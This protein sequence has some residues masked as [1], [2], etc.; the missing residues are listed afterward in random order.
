M[1]ERQLIVHEFDVRG[2]SLPDKIVDEILQSRIKERY[3]DRQTFIKTLRAE[4]STVEKMRRQIREQIIINAMLDKNVSSLLVVSPYKVES[5]YQAH[6]D[7][8]RVEDRVRLRLIMLD[9]SAAAT[10]DERKAL[11]QEI[12]RKIKHGASF[13]EMAALY[14]TGSHRTRGGEWGW[15]TRTELFKGLADIAFELEPGTPGPVIGY[16][17]QPTDYWVCTYDDAGQP[18]VARHFA[19]DPDTR[20]ERLVEERRFEGSS[21]HTNSFPGEVFYLVLVEEKSPAH[22][23]PLSEV[24]DEIEKTLLAQGQETLRKK[25]IETLKKKTFVRYF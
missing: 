25:W 17:G 6:L 16:A 21:A 7:E 12:L 4:G 1:V 3:G 5:Y 20:K 23:K 8:F 2:Y 10:I 11:A 13:A 22:V 24:R 15:A 14:S 18:L 19:T 9:Q